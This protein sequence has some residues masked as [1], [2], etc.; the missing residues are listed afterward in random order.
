MTQEALAGAL[1]CVALGVRAFPVFSV[2]EGPDDTLWCSC[3][4]GPA[5]DNPGK[6]PMERGWQQ[7][8]SANE[9]RVRNWARTYPGCNWGLL[10]E[11]LVMVDVD[12][13]NGGTLEGLPAWLP[14]T[15]W[16]V[17]TGGGGWHLGFRP[18]PG[19][20]VAGGKLMPGVDLKGKG[21]YVVAPGSD[22]ISGGQY[23][24]ESGP[25]WEAPVPIW[26]SQQAENERP[27][28]APSADRSKL[29]DLLANA[30]Q[31]E[32]EGRND[33]LTQV[34]GHLAKTVPYE[35]AYRAL[36]ISINDTIEEPLSR[37]ELDKI[38]ESIWHAEESKAAT[39]DDEDPSWNRDVLQAARRLRV[40]E[41]ARRRAARA[42]FVEPPTTL[43]GPEYLAVPDEQEPWTV[44]DLLQTGG[45]ALLAAAYKVGKTTLLLNMMKAACDGDRFLDRFDVHLAPGRRVGFWNYELSPAQ[46]RRWVKRLGIAAADRFAVLDLRGHNMRLGDP[47]INAWGIEWLQRWDVDLWIVDPFARSYGGQSENDNTEVARWTDALDAIKQ[48]AGVG[49]CVVG[50]HFGRQE[51]EDGGEHVRGATR[52]DDWADARWIMTRDAQEERF[53]K[54]T[55]RD[56]EVREGRLMWAPDR[57]GFSMVEGGKSQRRLGRIEEGVLEYL[58]KA[59]EGK[60][61]PMI[62]PGLTGKSIET[63]VEGRAMDV[64]RSCK[65]L[66]DKGA[67]VIVNGPHGERWHYP[68]EHPDATAGLFD[69]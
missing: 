8:A 9:R 65:D 40:Q 56:V 30:P 11:D 53:F 52:L 24:W 57:L 12:P 3:P 7:K 31:H 67:I 36:L 58:T 50:A 69:V 38:T 62:R 2:Q 68:E 48:Q 1:E 54:A 10:T 15:P 5:C 45:N 33:W 22:H 6:H 4:D 47:T 29:A 17:R 42:I 26:P 41:E 35:D 64:R 19:V 61:G 20:A 37:A 49:A 32:G 43:A 66:V 51:F 18:P 28:D 34:A 63:N 13:R 55:G 23:E 46:M 16:I 39:E 59:T 14:D 44:A 27:A 60:T 21:G 25:P